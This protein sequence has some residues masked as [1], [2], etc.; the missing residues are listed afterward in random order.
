MLAVDVPD[1]ELAA[2]L[3]GWAPPADGPAGGVLAR[4]RA[5]VGSAADGAVLGVPG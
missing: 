4:Y 1:A 2:R 5:C 3:E